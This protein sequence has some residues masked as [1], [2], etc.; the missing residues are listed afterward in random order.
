[1]EEIR[2]KAFDDELN[3]AEDRIEK[4]DKTPLPPHR[5]KKEKENKKE[6]DGEN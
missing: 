4:V 5:G 3:K 6:E 2:D 1:M